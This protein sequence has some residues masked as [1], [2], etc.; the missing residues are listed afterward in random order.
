MR[1]QWIKPNRLIKNDVIGVIAPSDCVTEKDIAPGI[2]LLENWGFRVELARHIYDSEYGFAAGSPEARAADLIEMIENKK[3]K[4]IWAA[5]GGYAATQLWPLTDKAM[6]E[7]IKK[8]PKW[9]IGYSDVG[10]LLNIWKSGGVMAIHGPNLSGLPY[11]NIE[12]QTWLR[13]LLTGE[14]KKGRVV[15]IDGDPISTGVV[16]G[17]L[18]IENLNTLITSFGTRFDPLEDGEDDLI[19]GVE[20]RRQFKSDIQR[21]IDMIVNHRK[22]KRIKGFILGRFG[23]FFVEKEYREWD[24][25]NSLGLLVLKRIVAAIGRI[26]VV[27]TDIFGHFREG[28]GVKE[29]LHL[30]TKPEKFLG[31]PNGIKTRLSIKNSGV[32]LTFLEDV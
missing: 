24:K 4:A 9:L 12:S 32:S 21:E 7:K 15:A 2:K 10:T 6:V 1:D 8:N 23:K 17:R 30:P 5:L 22:S 25:R 13:G 29:L 27:S 18:L 11:W 28:E 31:L 3:I 20:E 26:P 14:I 19:V 16:S